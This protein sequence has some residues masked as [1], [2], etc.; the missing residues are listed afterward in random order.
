MTEQCSV[1]GCDRPVLA[2]NLCQAHYDRLRRTGDVQKDRP[3][4]QRFRNIEDAFLGR[5]ERRGDCLIWT[6]STT[7][8]GYGHALIGGIHYYAHRYAWERENGPIP[9]GMTV[10][11][12]DH[13][14][15]ACVEVDHLRLATYSQNGR[16]RAGAMARSKTGVRNVSPYRG[17]YIVTLRKDGKR[18]SFGT[19][20]T[21]AE[22]AK[23]AEQARKDIYG[24]YAGK[25]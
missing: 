1:E 5:T 4:R 13:C 14:D 16:N 25:Q 10:D 12:K 18:L 20:S 6:G 15:P 23:V 22:A 24:E 2:R 19:Y 11:H 7:T 8:D 21:I 9:D 3:I 17:G